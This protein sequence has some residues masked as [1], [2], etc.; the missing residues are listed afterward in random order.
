PLSDFGFDKPFALDRGEM[1]LKRLSEDIGAPVP[2]LEPDPITD[3]QVLLVHTPEYLKTLAI[4]KTWID[5]FEFRESE[6]FPERATR[7]LPSIIDDFKLKSGGTLKASEL[8]LDIGLAANLGG[9]YHH[10]FPDQGRG[11]CPI[12][13]IAIA[14]R[15]LQKIGKIKKAL[16]V[17][18]D[19]HQGDGTAVAFRNDDSVFTFSVHSEE[20]WPEVK[21]Q[22]DLDIP[23]KEIEKEKY[24]EK[25]RAG[26]KLA[27]SKFA[28]DMVIYVAGS[29]PYEKDV[30]PGTSF[31]RLPLSVMKARDELVIDTFA[32]LGISL[33]SVFAG[34]YGPDVWEVHYLSTRRLLERSGLS[35][36]KTTSRC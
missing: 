11:Y 30:L 19:F 36:G 20:G 25:T 6:Y 9:G 29:D 28:P 3:E 7:P 35:F 10:A 31:F 12:N 33:A 27:L 32:D 22:S 4:P 8:S 15:H 13:D 34:G 23:I 2:Y 17:D 18:L 26:L 1:V 21:Q 5:L 14:I 16:I 24:L